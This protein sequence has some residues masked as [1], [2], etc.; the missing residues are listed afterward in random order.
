MIFRDIV[1]H[2]KYT[3][4]TSIIRKPGNTNIKKNIPHVTIIRLKL[5]FT[6]RKLSMKACLKLPWNVILGNV[7]INIIN[8]MK[9][10]NH[11]TINIK[12]ARSSLFNNSAISNL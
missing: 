9:K 1:T 12:I 7:D 11:R 3:L 6:I 5:L 4:V 10:I 8:Q 2:E